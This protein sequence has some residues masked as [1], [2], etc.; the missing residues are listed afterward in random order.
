M[1]G[2]GVAGRARG[3][4]GNSAAAAHVSTSWG[5]V[6]GHLPP[7]IRTEKAWRGTVRRTPGIGTGR[8]IEMLF[9]LRPKGME[10]KAFI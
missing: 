1:A 9:R 7:V 8:L 10:L 3:A 6:G 4:P 2:A 5:E